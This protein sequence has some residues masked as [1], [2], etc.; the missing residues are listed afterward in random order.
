MQGQESVEGKEALLQIIWGRVHNPA[1]R[2]DKTWIP[3]PKKHGSKSVGV[4]TQ[5]ALPVSTEIGGRAENQ[6]SKTQDVSGKLRTLHFTNRTEPVTERALI[7][8]FIQ[9]VCTQ[10]LPWVRY[11]LRYEDTMTCKNDRVLP[12]K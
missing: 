9:Q 12:S 1:F 3:P 11:C 4:C 2:S 7:Y 8:S 6:I 10:G 5:E